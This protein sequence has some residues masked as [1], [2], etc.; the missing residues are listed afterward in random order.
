MTKV[1]GELLSSPIDED[2]NVSRWFAISC[3][4]S[5]LDSPT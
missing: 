3:S 2:A 1:E 5:C 4:A